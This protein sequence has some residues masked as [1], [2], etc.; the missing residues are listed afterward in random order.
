MIEFLTGVFCGVFCALVSGLF[1]YV[2][3]RGKRFDFWILIAGAVFG[4]FWVTFN[5]NAFFTWQEWFLT[6][7]VLMLFEY[8]S[9][10][11]W[12]KLD[13]Q[14]N[15]DRERVFVYALNFATVVYIELFLEVLFLWFLPFIL[16]RSRFMFWEWEWER[17]VFRWFATEIPQIERDAFVSF[18]IF[19]FPL[20]AV[21]SYHALTSLIRRKEQR[22]KT[23]IGSTSTL[24]VRWVGE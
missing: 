11:V 17:W 9:K 21:F 15:A 4:V 8:G 23:K 20:M 7:A 13:L 2:C 14:V 1:G 24:K 12:R 22:V 6:V 18:I 5:A 19:G 16:D 3:D 10:T